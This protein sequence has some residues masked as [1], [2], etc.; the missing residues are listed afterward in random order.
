MRT[1]PYTY[2]FE[3]LNKLARRRRMKMGLQRVSDTPSDWLKFVDRKKNR[4]E[5][6]GNAFQDFEVAIL[7]YN[8]FSK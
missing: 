1:N 8:Y 5:I 3:S 6:P 4:I 7:R 2:C